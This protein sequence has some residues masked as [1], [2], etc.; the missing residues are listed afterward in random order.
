MTGFF[1]KLFS[2]DSLPPPFDHARATEDLLRSLP[3]CASR[4]VIASPRYGSHYRCEVTIDS[5]SLVEFADNA[6][7]F[8]SGGTRDSQVARSAFPRWLRNASKTD[9][10]VAYLLPAFTKIVS[11]YVLNFIRDGIAVVHCPDCGYIVDKIV[12]RNRNH[13]NRGSWSEWT[14]AWYCPSGH[15]LYTEDHEVHIHRRTAD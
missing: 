10:K 6:D 9:S 4:V 8:T 11:H 12:E 15:R 13:E 7:R 1:R 5:Y 14:A 3:L 2:R